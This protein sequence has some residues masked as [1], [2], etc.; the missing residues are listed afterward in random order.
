MSQPLALRREESEHALVSALKALEIERT[1]G[2]E[3]VLAALRRFEGQP[4]RYLD[5]PADLHPRLARALRSRGVERL[6]AHQREAYDAVRSGRHTVVVTPTASG[7]T[8]CYNLP[9]LDGILKD[10]AAR[11]L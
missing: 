2:A 5:F 9:V 6:Y 11:A 8:L 4:A 1:L 7:K 3:P 10:P